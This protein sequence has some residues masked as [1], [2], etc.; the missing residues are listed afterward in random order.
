MSFRD[1]KQKARRDL[2]N[3]L[4]V[5][6]IY[7]PDPKN[8][9][10]SPPFEITIRVHSSLNAIG[11]VKGTSYSYA[12]REA[13]QP[14]LVFMRDQVPQPAR[15]AV[16]VISEDEAYRVDVSQPPDLITI[17]CRVVRLKPGQFTGLPTPA[18]GC[19]D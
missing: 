2:H 10:T 8:L 14:K 3:E 15:D 1:I 17:T 13:V 7:V 5:A 16:V 12:E 11:D 4:K 19:C 9:Q 6:A 18:G